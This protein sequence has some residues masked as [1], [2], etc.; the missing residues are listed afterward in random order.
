[1]LATI[2]NYFVNPTLHNHIQVAG[3]MYFPNA[4]KVLLAATLLGSAAAHNI[5]LPA[6]G[7]ECFHENLHRDDKMTVTF[8]V[9]DREFGSAGNLDIDF[10]VCALFYLR[11]LYRAMMESSC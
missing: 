8:Q 4:A 5:Q 2:A 11:C 6:H 10:W 9:G 1:M 3:A 7:R